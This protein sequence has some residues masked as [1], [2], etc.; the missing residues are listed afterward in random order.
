MSEPLLDP[1]MPPA[2]LAAF[3]GTET[4]PTLLGPLSDLRAHLGAGTVLSMLP[5]HL[6]SLEVPAERLLEVATFLHD[7]LQFDLLSSVSGVDLV[8]HRAV[9]YHLRS[10]PHNWLLQLKV[11][12]PPDEML[13]SVIGVWPGANALERE[14]YDLFGIRFLGHP[15][16]RRIL[17]DDEFLGYP[18]LKSFRQTPQVVHDQATTQLDPA[19]AVALGSQEGTGGQRVKSNRLSQGPLERLHPGTPTLGDTQFHGRSFP[20]ETWK[21]RPEYQGTGDNTYHGDMGDNP[22]LPADEKK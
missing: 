20:P 4:Q 10:L 15:D 9:A 16:L 18:L 13:D 14:T 11:Q 17:T 8:T 21:H 2:P 6:P 22:Q 19:R 5:G 12:V 1:P 3:P 7:A